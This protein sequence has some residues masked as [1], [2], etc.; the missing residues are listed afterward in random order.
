MTG[1]DVTSPSGKQDGQHGGIIFNADLTEG[2]DYTIRVGRNLM[3]TERPDGVFML[4]VVVT[5]SYLRS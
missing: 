3:G 1:G 5:P 4:E 2:G